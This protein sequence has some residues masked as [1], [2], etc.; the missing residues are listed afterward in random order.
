MDRNGG[1]RYLAAVKDCRKVVVYHAHC[2]CSADPCLSAGCCS[3]G[4]C[5][6]RALLYGRSVRKDVRPVLSDGFKNKITACNN[7]V[8]SAH[9]RFRGILFHIL[10]IGRCRA[11]ASLSALRLRALLSELP[12]DRPA[13][14]AAARGSYRGCPVKDL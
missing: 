3:I 11:H 9:I 7:V 8:L 6:V 2:R 12:K 4:G 14:R 13:D 1:R 10:C 5:S